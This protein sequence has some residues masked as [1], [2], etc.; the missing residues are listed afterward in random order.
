MS[1]RSEEFLAS[2]RDRLAGAR[3]LLRTGHPEASA[4]IAYYAML[5]AAR[6][7][8]SEQELNAKT[9]RG[10]W[11]LFRD[12]FVVPGQFAESLYQTAQ[13]AQRLREAGDYEAA[14]ASR[15]EA[16]RILE[17]AGRFVAEIETLLGR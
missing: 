10:T 7:A 6:A 16:E 11:S 1:P 8:L 14:G 9:H 13:D 3:D 15:D 4:A 12:A 2:A 17:A 5:Y